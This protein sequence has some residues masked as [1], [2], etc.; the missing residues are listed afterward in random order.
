MTALSADRH[1]PYKEGDI[2]EYPV[3]AS[4]KIYN[5][6][7]V[8]INTSGYAVPAA[9][10]ANFKCAGVAEE[11]VDNSSGANGAKTVKVRT[12]GVFK[13]T[14]TSITQAMVGAAMYVKDDQTFDDTSTNSV[15]CG[16]LA[17]YESA[18]EGWIKL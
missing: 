12:R 5:G 10:T 3:A 14:A 13:F 8:G 11:Q 6:S 7:L 2:V 16:T 4:S 15:Q 18:T 17:R 1:T 9:D